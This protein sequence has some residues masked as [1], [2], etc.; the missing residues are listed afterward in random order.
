MLYFY[1]PP[2]DAD[3]DALAAQGLRAMASDAPMRLF[4]R[5]ADARDA[6]DGGPVLVVDGRALSAPPQRAGKGYVQCRTVPPAA[7]QNTAPYRAPVPVT[8]GGG[9][10]AC[11]LEATVVL[12]VIFRRGVWDLPKG[13]QDPGESVEACARR[14]VREEVGI[15]TLHL[16]R[17]LGTTRHGYV[18]DDRYE[19]KTTHWFLMRT[20]ERSFEPERREGIQRV[21][22]ARWPVARR[23]LGYETLRRHMDRCEA[24]VRTA[25]TAS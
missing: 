12:L 13:K 15:E 14:E 19:V 25:L 6:A 24:D 10:V 9:Y 2:P 3:L 22:W 4:T 16:L 8:A 7:L 21:A 17:P 23:H 11:P 1:C 20:P 18:R 5:L